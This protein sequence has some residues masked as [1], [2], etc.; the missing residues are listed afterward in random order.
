MVVIV[1]LLNLS[2]LDFL[3]SEIKDLELRKESSLYKIQ[4]E[5]EEECLKDKGVARK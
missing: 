1:V 3:K 2:F 4:E 5:C